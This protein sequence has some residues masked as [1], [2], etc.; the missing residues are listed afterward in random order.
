[1]NE[2]HPLE[3]R[4]RVALESAQ[5]GI[6]TWSRATGFITWDDHA[7]AMLG[8]PVEAQLTLA[9]WEALAHP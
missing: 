1:M 3:S 6:W 2:E 5:I 7:R 9:E 4:Y 8:I